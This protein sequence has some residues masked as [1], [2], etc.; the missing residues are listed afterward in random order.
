MDL[1]LTEYDGKRVELKLNDSEDIVVGTVQ[2]GAPEMI[3]FKEKGKASLT[4]VRLDEIEFIR[5]SAEAEP[6]LKA[7]RLNIVGLDTV[8]RHLADRHGYALE[9]INKMSS[10]DALAFHDQLDHAPLSHYHADPPS[11]AES[12]AGETEDGDE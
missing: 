5:L 11:K 2:S 9:D 12:E 8:K 4:L 1:D 3:A 10:E 7:R 6:E